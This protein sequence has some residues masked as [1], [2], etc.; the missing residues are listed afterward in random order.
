MTLLGNNGGDASSLF[1]FSA[2]AHT[3]PGMLCKDE[4]E[5]NHQV[6]LGIQSQGKIN[7]PNSTVDGN[8]I[9]EVADVCVGLVSS[10]SGGGLESN[11]SLDGTIEEKDEESIMGGPDDPCRREDGEKKGEDIMEFEDEEGSGISS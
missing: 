7:H 6:E 2:A 11:C 4:V 5:R 8:R 3:D 9:L 10:N 1:Q